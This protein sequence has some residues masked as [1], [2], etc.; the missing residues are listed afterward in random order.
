MSDA[1]QFEAM[2]L[3]LNAETAEG[4]NA[5]FEVKSRQRK[6]G[7]YRKDI[8]RSW[9]AVQRQTRNAY[10]RGEP[11]TTLG[12][13]LRHCLILATLTS[14]ANET[15]PV[16]EDSAVGS[17]RPQVAQGLAANGE[18]EQALVIVQMLQAKSDFI[19][20]GGEALIRIVRG[21]AAAGDTERAL[22]IARTM[23][24]SYY[25]AQALIEIIPVLTAGQLSEALSIAQTIEK[26]TKSDEF[27]HQSVDYLTVAQLSTAWAT[28]LT[29]Q[30]VS[31]RVQ[32]F[33]LMLQDISESAWAAA[34]KDSRR[35]MERSRETWWKPPGNWRSRVFAAIAKALVAFGDVEQALSLAQ[36]TPNASERSEVLI[37]IV[38]HLNATQINEVLS[39]VRKLKGVENRGQVFCEIAKALIALGNSERAFAVAQAIG[40]VYERVQVLI[41]IAPSLG[42]EQLN[43]ALALA[44]SV[45]YAPAQAVALVRIASHLPEAEQRTRILEEALAL[46]RTVEHPFRRV[47]ALTDI[48][49]CLPLGKER[50]RVLEEALTITRVVE[51]TFWRFEALA[52]I[53][54]YLASE[55]ERSRIL[56]EALELVRK[57]GDH[58]YQEY[59]LMA[60]AGRLDASQLG[61]AVSLARSIK[62]KSRR[63]DVGKREWADARCRTQVLCGIAA[64]L[65]R[66]PHEEFY[67]LWTALLQSSVLEERRDFLSVL[68][69]LAAVLLEK[70]GTEAMEELFRA[71]KDVERWWP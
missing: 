39:L 56:S 29:I 65:Q 1:E 34:E 45:A 69:P 60:I 37:E 3:R 40:D 15:Q 18:I 50:S 13:E 44:R 47:Q 35:M 7:R 53:A 27:R 68:E 28:L 20:V 71:I 14:L 42:A 16:G 55:E 24:S 63:N 5:W 64:Q 66:V 25:R 57:A 32:A 6:L 26:D 21:L 30:D 8:E 67:P 52:E 23:R 17:M 61:E 36:G 10:E 19:F 22:A 4:K 46:A 31:N 48:A 43:K 33:R 9:R 11:L 38:G 70:G 41:D 62:D 54:D 49:A 58:F 51:Y 2:I 59:A 12:L